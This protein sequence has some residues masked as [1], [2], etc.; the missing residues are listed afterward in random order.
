MSLLRFVTHLVE[1]LSHTKGNWFDPNL[2]TSY[3]LHNPPFCNT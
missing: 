2:N 3:D 1:Y